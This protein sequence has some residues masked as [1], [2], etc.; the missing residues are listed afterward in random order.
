[1][2]IGIAECVSDAGVVESFGGAFPDVSKLIAQANV[3]SMPIAVNI[4]A[5][6]ELLDVEEP[7]GDFGMDLFALVDHS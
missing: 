2:P 1:M 4:G 7:A 3:I 5:R 6:F